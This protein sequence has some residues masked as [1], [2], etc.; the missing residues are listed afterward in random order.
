MKKTNIR[1]F[2]KLNDI[3]ENN[4]FL[5]IK[6]DNLIKYIDLEDNK[7]TIDM[8]KNIIIRENK[9]YLFN[10]DFN[11]NIITINIKKIGKVLEKE[12]NTMII[13]KSETKYLIR[14]LLTDEN[15]INE[16]YVKFW[17]SYCIINNKMV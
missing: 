13:S 5:A 2:T 4:E 3:E 6:D 7:M 9:D 15:I 10:M 16:Y 17:N 14:Y 8:E 11:N 1:V 12:I